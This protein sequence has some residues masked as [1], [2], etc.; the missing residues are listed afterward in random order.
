VNEFNAVLGTKNIFAIGDVS[1]C[2]TSENPQGLPMLAP[3]AQQ[4][5]EHL[6][7]NILKN[8]ANEPMDP[9][10]YHNK[11]VMA[12]IGRKKAVVDLP[13]YKFQGGFAWFVWMFV[14]I[15]SLVGFRDKIV[16]FID[17]LAN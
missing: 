9:F 10:E 3:V 17:W 11:G 8:I 16:T 4:Q 12:T 2:I 15:I 5:A 7:K 1:A 14:H 13:N 6:A